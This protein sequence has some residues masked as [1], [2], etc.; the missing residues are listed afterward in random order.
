MYS[1]VLYCTVMYCNVLNCTVLTLLRQAN[2]MWCVGNNTV[3]FA[4]YS[5]YIQM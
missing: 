1:T 5:V 2:Y 4:G 3:H